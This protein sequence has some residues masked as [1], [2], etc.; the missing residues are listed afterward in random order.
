M[1]LGVSITNYSWAGA[2]LTLA[3]HIVD[4]ARLVDDAG[5]D[6]LW[7]ADHLLQMDPSASIDEPMLEAY[8][9]LAFIAGATQRVQ[10]GTMVTWATIRPPA[11]LIK[12]VTTLDVLSG[13]RAWLGVGIG[14]RGDEAAMTGLPFEPTPERFSRLEELLQLAAQMWDGDRA[15]FEG[16]HH[17]LERP[18]NEPA[19]IARPRVLIGGMGE[20]RTLPLVARYADACNLFDIPDQGATLRRKLDVLA[21]AC[22]A[23]GRDR[24][25]IEVTL[26]T[27]LGDGETATQLCDRAA[28][29]AD[30]GVDHLVFVTT[31]P[32]R[33]GGDIDV[34]VDAAE[35]L[36]TIARKDAQL[37][38]RSRR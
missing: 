37:T 27:R 9:T 17:R 36:H 19:P 16:P 11:L 7:V 28:S 8:A 25:E 29:L 14:Y 26:S 20:Q 32:W 4:L 33:T 24:H 5:I 2:P 10:L 1:R 30:V 23:A 15:P 31:G 12:T 13:G 18:V 6:T 22:D 21:R 35:A 38:G 34:L 3:G